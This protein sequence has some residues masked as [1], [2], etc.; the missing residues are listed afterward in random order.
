VTLYEPWRVTQSSDPSLRVSATF[1]GQYL[2][3]PNFLQRNQD[4]EIF[5]TEM[6]MKTSPKLPP[7]LSTLEDRI[8]DGPT[9]YTYGF[10]PQMLLDGSHHFSPLMNRQPSPSDQFSHPSSGTEVVGALRDDEDTEMCDAS[11]AMT[12]PPQVD[13]PYMSECLEQ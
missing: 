7:S 2:E 11:L 8:N 1:M 13:R 10:P 6:V 12:T 5:V 9:G 3:H 4:G